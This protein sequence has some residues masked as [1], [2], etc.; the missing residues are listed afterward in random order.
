MTDPDRLP[1]HADPREILAHLRDQ[2]AKRPDGYVTEAER[3]QIAHLEARIAAL[4]PPED[5]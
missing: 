1:H 5:R 4:V 2:L 3:Q